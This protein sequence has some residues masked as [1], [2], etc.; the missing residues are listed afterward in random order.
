MVKGKQKQAK[1]YNNATGIA[2]SR[3][4]DQALQDPFH[5]AHRAVSPGFLLE[6][7]E[8]NHCWDLTTNEVMGR[9]VAPRTCADDNF[10]RYTDLLPKAQVGTVSVLVSHTW[11][12]PWGLLVATVRKFAKDFK[13]HHKDHDPGTKNRLFFWVDLFAIPQNARC[14]SI[15]RHD[16]LQLEMVI[17]IAKNVLL[18]CDDALKPL[19]RVW[20]L[21][22]VVVGLKSGP[23]GKFQLRCGRLVTSSSHEFQ[24]I[25]DGDTLRAMAEGLDLEKANATLEEDL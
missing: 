10:L 14:Q 24:P 15:Q 11:S 4:H 5:A 6:F 22:E 18:V 8:S 7:T 20:C 12:N 13:E 16:L 23:Y 21:F 17:E 1:D 2:F 3:D 19:T 25:Q 9:F